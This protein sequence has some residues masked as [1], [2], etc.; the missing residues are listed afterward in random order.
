ME[1]VVQKALALQRRV[2]GAVGSGAGTAGTSPGGATAGTAVAGAAGAGPLLASDGPGASADSPSPHAPG[3]ADSDHPATGGA[4]GGCVFRREG[5]YW[6]IAYGRNLFRLK[7]SVGLHYV[8]HLLRHPGREFLAIDLVA[9]AQERQGTDAPGPTRGGAPTASRQDLG[10]QIVPGLGDAGEMLDPQAKAAYKRRV[11]DLRDQ[12]GEA[13]RFN[14]LDRAAQLQEELDFLA[15]ELSRAVGLGGRDRKAASSAER[16]RVN[17]TRTIKD[18]IRRIADN[19]PA[20]GGHL[21]ATIKTG[22][23]CVYTPDPRLRVAWTL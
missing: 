9:E 22:T 13:Q 14:D 7:D 4:A 21:T 12:L 11:E 19:D 17:V 15:K 18:A 8:A 5:E 3:S 2:E 16:A 10:E 6:T 1:S 23:Y 20:L